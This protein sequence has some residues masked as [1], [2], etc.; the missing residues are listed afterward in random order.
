MYGPSFLQRFITGLEYVLAVDGDDSAD[1]RVLES[2]LA[3]VTSL[4]REYGLDETCWSTVHCVRDA[5][6]LAYTSPLHGS[7]GTATAAD[8]ATLWREHLHQGLYVPTTGTRGNPAG[9]RALHAFAS[10]PRLV[11]QVQLI[12]SP[13]DPAWDTTTYVNDLAADLQILQPLWDI[14][15]DLPDTDAAR[16]HLVAKATAEDMPDAHAT[17]FDVVRAAGLSR[18]RSYSTLADPRLTTFETI[19]PHDEGGVRSPDE[20]AGGDLHDLPEDPLRT[21]FGIHASG[22]LFSITTHTG[23]DASPVDATT[24][25]DYDWDKLHRAATRAGW[26]A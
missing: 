14:P 19:A 10:A 26:A 2:R 12:I 17:V 20:R 16:L 23:T 15:A 3:F 25:L 4:R 18:T 11:T 24:F 21:R 1:L 5:D 7:G 8:L 6:P 9:Q 22:A 13:D